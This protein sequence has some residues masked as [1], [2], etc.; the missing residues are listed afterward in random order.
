M[1]NLYR[2]LQ[3]LDTA[4]LHYLLA[5]YQDDVVTIH[6]SV[7]G[8]RIEID[9]ESDGTVNTCRFIGDEGGELGMEVVDEIIS[10]YSE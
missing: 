6:V 1:H 8:E 4:K 3:K 10:E 5:R 2:I 9:V 7:P